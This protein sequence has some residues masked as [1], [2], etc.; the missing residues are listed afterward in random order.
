[1]KKSI[2]TLI[3]AISIILLISVF[4][5]F[6]KN[7]KSI[8]DYPNKMKIQ[9]P[10]F[11][12]N[13]KIPDRYT[14]DGEDINPPLIISEIP[15][16]AKFLALINDDPDAPIGGWVHWVIFNIPVS[17]T[18][19]E[20]KENST[21]ENAVLGINDFKKLKYGGPAPPSGTHRYFFKVYALDNK[22]NLQEGASKSQVEKAMENHILDK[23]ELIGLYSR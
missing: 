5:Y 20:I 18:S 16:N 14:A 9:S 8:E 1:M 23:A 7:Q 21:P 15:K 2:I 10:A 19:L 12:N 22:L 4:I 3:F 6:N 11:N 17:G 13:E